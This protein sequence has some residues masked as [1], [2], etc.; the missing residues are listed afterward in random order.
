M[1]DDRR[2][3]HVVLGATGGSGYAVVEELLDR[4]LPVRA[5][6]RSPGEAFPES[7]EVHAADCTDRNETV[8]ACA[9]AAAVYQC[10]GVPYERWTELLPLIWDNAVEAA[11]E[12]DAPLVVMD[13]LYAYGPT[14]EPMTEETPREPE[15]PKGAIRHELEKMLFR[16]HEYDQVRVAIGRASDFYGPRVNSS[17]GE[18]V[19]DAAVDVRTA[20]WLGSLDAPHT[21]SYL[22]DVARGLV[23]LALNEEAYGEVW[24][25]PANDPVTGRRFIEM[26]FE[27]VGGEPKMRA[28]GYWSLTFAGLFNAQIREVKEV[29][30][31][32]RD[33]FVMDTTKFENEFGRE[34][35]PYEEAIAATVDWHRANAD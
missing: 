23:T 32:F 29:L 10:I 1:S 22:P 17:T 7:V 9:D 35:T 34:V 21:M 20:A 28:Y 5:V 24:H 18:L 30:Y 12:A 6:S 19:F 15:G 11:G 31:Q 16:A 4:G 2:A 13:N 8:A 26:V 14:D 25:L 33:P 3:P 27:E